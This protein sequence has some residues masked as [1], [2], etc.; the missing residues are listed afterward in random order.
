M[1]KKRIFIA[2]IA[3]TLVVSAFAR[4]GLSQRYGQGMGGGRM[5]GQN[6]LTGEIAGVDQGS[7]TIMT[8]TGENRKVT[9]TPETSFVRQTAG[10]KSDLVI[11]DSAMVI[12]Q[13]FGRNAVAPMMVI[14]LAKM[15]ET[16]GSRGR[17]GR[18]TGGQSMG[19]GMQGP[20]IGAI[21]GTDPLTIQGA[22]GETTV[23]Q[24]TES[25]RIIKETTIYPS[26]L[27]RGARVRIM[28]SQNAG[29]GPQEARKVILLP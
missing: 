16:P 4:P 6:M 2:L 8:R 15:V 7:L 28:L 14:L 11:G 24:L 23:A 26:G 1:D 13:P 9:I 21:I 18:K 10:D 25:T 29:P 22:S 19:G 20:V 5:G 17:M 27:A 12:G 3:G